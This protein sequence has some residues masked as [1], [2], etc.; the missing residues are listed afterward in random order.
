MMITTLFTELCDKQG[1][2][3]H[4]GR[5]QLEDSEQQ[6]TLFKSVGAAREDL[7]AAMLAYQGLDDLS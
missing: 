4:A 7:A 6:I 2:N 5:S 3:H 1:G